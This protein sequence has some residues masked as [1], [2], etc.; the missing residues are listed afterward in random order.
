MAREPEQL[1]AIRQIVRCESDRIV[2]R[3]VVRIGDSERK[4][5][6]EESVLYLGADF[7]V[8]EMVYPG[9]ICLQT[10]VG[11]LA[12]LGDGRG[13]I[14]EWIAAG[15]VDYLVSPNIRVDRDG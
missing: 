5:L 3:D 10:G 15:S 13:L 7:D 11:Q 9:K 6:V 4:I 1:P 8:V 12:G 14:R 2:V